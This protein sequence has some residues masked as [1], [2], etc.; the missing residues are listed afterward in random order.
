MLGGGALRHAL[1]LAGNRR[2]PS[3]P[4]GG[5]G[6]RIRS[7]RPLAPASLGL[8]HQILKKYSQALPPLQECVARAP[9]LR[10]GHLWLAATYAQLRKVEQARAEAAEVL[11]VDPTWTSLGTARRICVFKR[12]EDAEHFFDGLRKAG[13]PE[14]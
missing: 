11:R 10:I 12:A 13:L 4:P 1:V 3:R 7:T 14:K 2:E 9:N 6:D 5:I 8:A